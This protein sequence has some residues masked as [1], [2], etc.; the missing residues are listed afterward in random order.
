MDTEDR[1]Q[2]VRTG[3]FRLR[4][5]T[6][7]GP[8]G[9]LLGP[10]DWSVPNRGVVAL[11]GPAGSGKT[12]LLR[13]LAAQSAEPGWIRGGGWF[14]R[15]TNLLD[16]WKCQPCEEEI[17]WLPQRKRPRVFDDPGQ[18]DPSPR[19]RETFGPGVRTALLDEP[20]RSIPRHEREELESFIRAFAAS[21]TVVLVTH[22]QRFAR[23]V[24]DRVTL[25]CGGQIIADEDVERF[26][27]DPPNELTERFVRQGNCSPPAVETPVLP[28]HFRWILDDQLAGM[29]R[30]GLLGHEDDDLAAIATAGI[31]HLVS[32]TDEPFSTDKLQAHGLSGR[33]FPIADMGVPSVRR[34]ATLCRQIERLVEGGSKVAL[35]CHAGLGRTGTM[36]A[37]YLVWIGVAPDEAVRR[38][39]AIRSSYIQVAAQERFVE[40]FAE[41]VPPPKKES[42]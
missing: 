10:L 20:E 14:Y 21:G 37:A 31:T 33:H 23:A 34:A 36:A 40:Q 41:C 35:H 13:T 16:R 11:M 29:G 32:M 19:W 38:V 25:L 28:E 6:I 18:D 1:G 7:D 12:A 4:S 30:P 24:A 26:F 8:D 5:V 3:T 9:R 17:R 2:D 22:D 15:G 39:R 27:Q 42:P